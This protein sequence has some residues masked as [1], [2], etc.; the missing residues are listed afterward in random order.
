MPS[1]PQVTIDSNV[2]IRYVNSKQNITI[3]HVD[4][5]DAYI[6]SPEQRDKLQQALIQSGNEKPYKY[7]RKENDFIVTGIIETNQAKYFKLTSKAKNFGIQ[8][9]FTVSVKEA[10]THSL[11]IG[12]STQQ[13]SGTCTIGEISQSN[14]VAV[15]AICSKISYGKTWGVFLS[16]H[17]LEGISSLLEFPPHNNLTL[18]QTPDG[19]EIDS[20]EYQVLETES[21]P[22]GEKSVDEFK[23]PKFYDKTQLEQ[24]FKTCSISDECKNVYTN[25]STL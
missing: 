25:F 5:C 14:K 9:D 24:F 19:I 18:E 8:L 16:K 3:V 20:F 13:N 15:F 1:L 6:L 4:Q 22:A 2:T 12:L 21:D 11:E 23:H 17:H 7:H 10:A